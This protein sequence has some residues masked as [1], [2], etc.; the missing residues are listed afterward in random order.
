MKK[1]LTKF[2][3]LMEKYPERG[4]QNAFD[5]KLSLTELMEVIVKLGK[6]DPI[7]LALNKIVA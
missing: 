5:A 2:V 3:S 1:K 4:V 6:N 7:R